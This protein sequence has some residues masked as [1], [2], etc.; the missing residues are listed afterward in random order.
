VSPRSVGATAAARPHQD[1][2]GGIIFRASDGEN[3]LVVRAN[4]LENNFRLYTM[5]GGRRRV[6]ASANVTPPRLRE[7]HSIRVVA[8]GTRIQAYLDGALLLDLVDRTYTGGYVGL[9]TKA[10]SVTEF[11]D[12]EISGVVARP[13]R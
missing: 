3:Y 8:V 5:V 11:V 1:A 9:W 12:L 6:I 13:T 7:W 2:S 4:A 10:D